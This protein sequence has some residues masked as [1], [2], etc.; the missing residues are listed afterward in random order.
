MNSWYPRSSAGSVKDDDIIGKTR[1]DP[2]AQQVLPDPRNPRSE[3]LP[4]YTINEDTWTLHL[5]FKLY[6]RKTSTAVELERPVAG[7]TLAIGSIR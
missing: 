5:G 1:H 4:K 3:I 2:F 6:P 7:S